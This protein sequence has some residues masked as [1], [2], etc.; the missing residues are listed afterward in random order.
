MHLVRELWRET[1]QDDMVIILKDLTVIFCSPAVRISNRKMDWSSNSSL[2]YFSIRI[3]SI[4][5][6]NKQTREEQ[7]LKMAV[8]LWWGS[9]FSVKWDPIEGLK[10]SRTRPLTSWSSRYPRAVSPTASRSV[11]SG[12]QQYGSRKVGV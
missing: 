3:C 1:F 4:S 8:T 12:I 6:F 2:L 10:N 7:G 11:P 9:G 5:V